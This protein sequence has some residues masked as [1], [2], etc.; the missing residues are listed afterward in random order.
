MG[1]DRLVKGYAFVVVA[2]GHPDEAKDDATEPDGGGDGEVSKEGNNVE[3]E[4][5]H[6]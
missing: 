3:D 5:V 4:V 6:E 1:L 2:G